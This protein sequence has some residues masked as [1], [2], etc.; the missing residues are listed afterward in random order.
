MSTFWNGQLS[1]AELFL[2]FSAQAEAGLNSQTELK[3]TW[4]KIEYFEMFQKK[5]I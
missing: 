4:T 3:L 2:C 1:P 5:H